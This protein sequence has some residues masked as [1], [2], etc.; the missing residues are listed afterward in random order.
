MLEVIRT[1]NEIFNELITNYTGN[2]W[3]YIWFYKIILY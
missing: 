3:N 1:L 2:Q